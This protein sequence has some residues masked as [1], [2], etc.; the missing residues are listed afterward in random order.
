V[1]KHNS[2]QIYKN[3][4]AFGCLAR[5]YWMFLGNVIVFFSAI[6]IA[7][8]KS[9]SFLTGLDWVFCSG[10]FSIILFR[11]LDVSYFK[12]TRP[13]GEAATMTD[14]VASVV[15]WGIAHLLKSLLA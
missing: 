12:G 1:S 6:S 3:E 7:L 15:V 10:V 13:D 8:S 11:Y 14:F 2:S 4:G 9:Q 5:L